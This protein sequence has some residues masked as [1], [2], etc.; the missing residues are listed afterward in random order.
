ML[1]NE[2]LRRLRKEA[3]LIQ[4]D[5]AAKLNIKRESY[6]RYETGD[7]QPPNDQ[8]VRLADFFETTAD[9]LLGL[10]DDPRPSNKKNS[11]SPEKLKLLDG[12]GY[13]YYGTEEKEL[14]DEDVDTILEIVELTRKMKEKRDKK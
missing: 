9:Y 5:V 1:N 6:T 8:V 3:G 13:A 4:A 7:I 14:D 10:T 11:L 2:R 12:I